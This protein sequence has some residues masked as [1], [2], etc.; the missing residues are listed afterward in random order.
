MGTRCRELDIYGQGIALT[1]KGQSKY[2]TIPGAIFS[3]LVLMTM[4]AFVASKLI[5]LFNRLNPSVSKQSYIKDLDKEPVLMGS[6][7]GFEFAFGF[8]KSFDKTYGEFV[9]NQVSFDYKYAE[10]GGPRTRPKVKRRLN[11]EECGLD[12]FKGF[13]NKTML[14]M[15]GIPYMKCVTN[16]GGQLQG[17][18]YSEKFKYM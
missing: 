8:N 16:N 2:K 6:D 1:F 3:L 4:A 14:D 13:N 9:V 5:I 18:F 11:L 15:Y 12:H 7:Y 10:D 17:D